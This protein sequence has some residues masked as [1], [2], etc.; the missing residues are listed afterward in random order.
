MEEFEPYE[1]ECGCP[2]CQDEDEHEDE[3]KDEPEESA[4]LCWDCGSISETSVNGKCNHCQEAYNIHEKWKTSEFIV[5]TDCGGEPQG[6]SWLFPRRY[7]CC[8]CLIPYVLHHLETDLQSTFPDVLIDLILQY[9]NNYLGRVLV[10]QNMLLD[11]EFLEEDLP[12]LCEARQQNLKCRPVVVY[13]AGSGQTFFVD[14]PETMKQ[15]N[16]VVVGRNKIR[17]SGRQTPTLISILVV[18]VFST[19]RFLLEPC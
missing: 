14:P 16:P 6:W 19:F 5:C 1:H 9:E 15:R 13:P 18:F 10:A 12:G 11:P 17:K 2:L 8:H 3:E 4:D 7:L